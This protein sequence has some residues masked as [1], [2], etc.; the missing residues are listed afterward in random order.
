MKKLTN[1]QTTAFSSS[2]HWLSG[3]Q[4]FII[5]IWGVFKPQKII[6]YCNELLKGKSPYFAFKDTL[7]KKTHV[8]K[9]K[10]S[11]SNPGGNTNN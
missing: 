2:L 7:N 8:L 9:N 5:F 3:K 6:D 10:K 1:E 4:F 11:Q